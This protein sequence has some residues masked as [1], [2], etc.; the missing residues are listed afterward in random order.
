MRLVSLAFFLALP[1]AL[2]AAARA[3]GCSPST[4]GV[5]SVAL[6]GSRTLHVRPNGLQG[7]LAAY[8]LATG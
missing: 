6:P 1:L 4:C 7:P 8:D 2:G 5:Q 3:D